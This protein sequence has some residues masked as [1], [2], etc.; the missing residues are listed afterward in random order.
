MYRK[1]TVMFAII[2]GGKF[3]KWSFFSFFSS[4]TYS[5]SLLLRHAFEVAEMMFTILSTTPL[6]KLLDEYEV[7]SLLIACFCHDLD[8]RGTNNMFEVK[9]SSPLHHLY[10]TSTMVGFF[11]AAEL[12]W[13]FNHWIVINLL[14]SFTRNII[15]RINVWW[16]VALEMTLDDFF[17]VEN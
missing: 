11:L 9:S 17:G 7:L 12:C 4:F 6:I 8:H 1:T 10:S 13:S 14:F 2:I 3:Q 15:T 5:L 16:W